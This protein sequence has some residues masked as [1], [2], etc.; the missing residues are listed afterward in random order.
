MS[1]RVRLAVLFFLVTGGGIAIVGL[2][3]FRATDGELTDETDAFLETRAN[4]LT[5]GRRAP[6]GDGGREDGGRRPAPVPLPFDPDAVVQT[7]GK[8]GQVTGTSSNTIPISEIDME[9]VFE[10]ASGGRAKAYQDVEIDGVAHRVYTQALPEGGAIQVAR[11]TAEN[12]RVLDSLRNQLLLIGLAVAA[13]AGGLGWVVAIRTTQPL[14]R[15]HLAAATVAESG[16]FD[17]DIDVAR[18]DEVGALARSFQEMLDAL[19]NSRDQQHRLVLDAGHELRTPLTSMRANI[20]LLERAEHM[21]PTDRAELLGAVKAELGEL[22]ELFGE[23]IELATD[24]QDAEPFVHLDL[25]AVAQR[26]ADRLERRS[27]RDVTVHGDDSHVL[28]DAT[29][30]ERAVSN[31]LSNAHKFS[32]PDTPIEIVIS[33]GRVAVRDRGPGI[34]ASERERIFDRFYRSDRT[35][36][37]PG[38]GLGLA[39]VAQIAEKHDGHVWAAENPAGVGAEVGLAIPVSDA[40]AP[41]NL[42]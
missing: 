34:P 10:G 8:E 4:D 2:L 16:D 19:A 12:D 42:G 40:A 26:S 22:N 39:I 29:L 20:A 28:G 3:A 37:M 25:S 9:I 31:L 35:R 38:S 1:L 33:E 23:L 32:P 11:A 15:L 5:Q 24:S 6:P 21:D 7:L 27:D 13:L 36:S 30:L 17:T 18:T 14:R 41:A